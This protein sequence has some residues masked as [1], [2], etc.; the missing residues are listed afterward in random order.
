M[1][2]N[3]MTPADF[4]AIMGRDGDWGGNNFLWVILFLFAMGGGNGFG[5]NRGGEYG[6]YATAAS[7]QE[8]LF[9]QR[10]AD[11]GN[12]IN[13]AYGALDNKIDRGFTSI[14]NGIADAT[15]ALNGAVTTEGRNLQMQ[16]A[17]CCCGNKEATAQVRYDMANFAA[18]INSNIDNK[19]AALEKAGLEQTIAAQ[20]ARINQ[21]ELASSLCGVVRY[22]NTMAYN[23]GQSPFC[24]CNY[25]GCNGNM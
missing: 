19:F 22:P 10:F 23:A 13:D 17:E 12:R 15:F 11:I 20:N 1:A 21:L 16:L 24:N 2:E 25:G 5:W 9:G 7:Q 3:M 8:I 18:Q 6:Q 14:G 4:S